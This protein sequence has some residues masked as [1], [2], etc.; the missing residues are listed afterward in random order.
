MSLYK[1]TQQIIGITLVLLFLSGCAALAETPIPPTV[2]PQ[3]E[4]KLVTALVVRH[5][6]KSAFPPHDPLLT[7]AGQA[8]SKALVHVAGEF[9][10]TAIYSSPYIRNLQTASPLATHLGLPVTKVDADNVEALVEKVLSDHTGEVV[11]IVGHSNTV[12]AIIEEFGGNP[13]PLITKNDYDDLFIVAVYSSW[14]S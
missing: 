3:P 9:D 5:A 11:L 8:R 4:I 10:V 13:I 12:P 2:I 7:A 6:E 14:W 1:L